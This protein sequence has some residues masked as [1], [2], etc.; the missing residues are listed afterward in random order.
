MASR[1]LPFCWEATSGEVI[2]L[3]NSY[4][5][6]ILCD[7]SG[8]HTSLLLQLECEQVVTSL[9]PVVHFDLSLSNPSQSQELAC[10]PVCLLA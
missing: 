1:Y 2:L 8:S 9:L 7:S 3:S 5:A 4:I 6:T 10:P